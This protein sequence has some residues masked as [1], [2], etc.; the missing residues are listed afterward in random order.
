MV[1]VPDQEQRRSIIEAANRLS[2]QAN[3]GER[4][5]LT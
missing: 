3:F 2:K 5:A 1:T 4:I